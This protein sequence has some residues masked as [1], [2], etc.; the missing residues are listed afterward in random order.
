MKIAWN[1]RTKS[2]RKHDPRKLGNGYNHKLTAPQLKAILSRYQAGE[3]VDAIAADFNISCDYP[4][5][6]ARRHGLKMRKNER[7]EMVRRGTASAT[8][9]TSDL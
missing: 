5:K 6:L 8:S 1:G 2:K 9:A 7:W 3:P 4:S